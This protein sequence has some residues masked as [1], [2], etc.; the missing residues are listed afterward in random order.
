MI[1]LLLSWSR[2]SLLVC[3]AGP[4][5]PYPSGRHQFDIAVIALYGDHAQTGFLTGICKELH[6]ILICQMLRDI[7]EER[8]ERRQRS[9]PQEECFATRF[10]GNMG[11]FN[12]P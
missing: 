1:S 8:S 11:E 9:K 2:L 7:G 3:P 4:W 10:V 6:H 5:N 12:L